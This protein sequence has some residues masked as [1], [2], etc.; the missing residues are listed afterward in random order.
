[1]ETLVI[2]SRF[3]EDSYRLLPI[4]QG[5]LFHSLFE[6]DGGV[7]I[8]QV[9][10]RLPKDI[11]LH[12][13]KRAW[14]C[15]MDRY[16]A[17]RTS[18]YWKGMDDP[19][20]LPHKKILVEMKVYDWRHIAVEDEPEK[21]KK[22]LADDRSCS[23]VLTKP[24]LMRFALFQLSQGEH[25]F[26]WTHHHALLD[27][28]AR[29]MVL[30]EVARFYEAFCSNQGLDL[31]PPVA[32]KDYIEWFWRQN[33]AD[34]RHYWQHL[35]AGD[36]SE[37]ALTPLFQGETSH[38]G[39]R[40]GER[41]VQLSPALTISLQQIAQKNKVTVTMVLQAAWGSLLGRYT[42]AQ[43]VVFGETR[44]CR[45][46]AFKGAST[47]VG[48]L[49]NTVPIKLCVNSKQPFRELLEALREQH[50]ALREH[51]LAALSDIRDWSGMSKTA[52]MFE[53]I[54]V[55]EE[56]ALD[57]VLR[58]EGARLWER[59]I[60]RSSPA[61]YP[62]ALTGYTKPELLLRIAHDRSKV[63]DSFAEHMVGHLRTLLDGVAKD[64]EVWIGML[65]L[66][67]EPEIRQ[68]A[69][70]NETKREYERGR[71]VHELFEEQVRRDPEAVAVVFAGEEMS[72]GELNRRANR[73]AHYL[74]GLGVKPDS[75]VGICVERS[76]EMMVGLLGVLKA[77]GAYV[78]LDPAYP[79]E[80]LSYMVED[81]APAVLLT[82]GQLGEVFRELNSTVPIVDLGEV[83][84]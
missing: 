65:P 82:Q 36:T 13:F 62:L 48:V 80:R 28:R 5:M 60:Y 32:Y 52:E 23:F 6:D 84:A 63:N 29:A 19:L 67:T 53:S 37:G 22:H 49:M 43:D 64:P 1:M 77:G 39:E 24:P 81:S 40:Y 66:L 76:M 27:G 8:G 50:I 78:P 44:A 42:G 17:L 73:L 51:D 18:F 25:L 69:E 30:K 71:C 2:E 59:G 7:Y 14:Q 35:F 34:T 38:S 16:A 61:H 46:P 74:R 15:V 21:L 47:V 55:F 83:S 56:S 10:G 72:Y 11:D 68:L 20:Q 9:V 54:V 33:K 70:W 57:Y 26:L 12:A 79:R 4:Q 41:E 3:L 58:R 31:P 45:R 75:R